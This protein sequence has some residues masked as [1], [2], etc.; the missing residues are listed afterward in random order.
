MLRVAA[1][2]DV[3]LFGTGELECH[4]YEAERVR[5][6]WRTKIKDPYGPCRIGVFMLDGPRTKELVSF[7][8]ELDT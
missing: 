4:H 7:T 2:N 3:H 5:G 6:S 1:E 8:V